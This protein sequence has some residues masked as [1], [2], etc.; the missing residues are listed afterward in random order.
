[1]IKQILV[2]TNKNVSTN[3]PKLLRT[4]KKAEKDYN[5][6]RKIEAFTFLNTLLNK[7]V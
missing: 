3:S 1:M 4:V 7:N 2:N 5:L 6:G